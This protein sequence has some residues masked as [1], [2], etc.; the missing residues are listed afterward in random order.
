MTVPSITVAVCTKDRPEMLG[1]LLRS[2]APQVVAPHELL[3]VDNAPST[4]R[5][6]DLVTRDF[7][8]ARYVVEPA[9]GLNF[10]RNRALRESG[11]EIVAY[12]DDDAVADLDWVAQN[13][14]VFAERPAIALCTGKV[15][16]L[17]LES[18]GARLFE[19]C[20]GFTRG[21]ERIHLPPGAGAPPP[22]WP[23][24]LIAWSIGIGFG[25]SMAIRRSVALSL[26]GFDEALDMGAVLPGGGDVDM[27][28]RVLDAGHE[29]VYEPRVHAWHEHRRELAAA[30]QQI[31]GHHRA[32]IAYLT[33]AVGKTRWPRK[34]S[35]VAFLLWRL[36]KPVVR[37]GK[38]AVGR[39]PLSAR[40]LLRLCTE[41][42]R[43]LGAYPR[44]VRLAGER[45]RLRGPV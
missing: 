2:L 28:F 27:V 13:A 21:D 17:S 36:V 20:G 45:A 9:P 24:P 35:V 18:D 41:T 6:R 7:P 22:G 4:S 32:T 1:R 8:S 33:K 11:A 25:V 40:T 34:A 31:L 10:A 38:R 12:I 19:A 23:R 5:T 39:D 43:G 29:L 44:A 15:D 16:A 37:L 14:A 26:G 30:E 3:V 42:W